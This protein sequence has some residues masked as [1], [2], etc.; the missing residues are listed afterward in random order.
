MT[1]QPF[2]VTPEWSEQT[3]TLEPDPQQ[4]LCL[5]SRHDLTHQYGYGHIADVLSNVDIDI[6]L[7]LYALDVAPAEPI[8]GDPHILRAGKDYTV[9]PARLA[10]GYVMLD[11]VRIEFAGS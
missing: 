1:D 10:Q 8:E 11:R 3:A 7:V 6:I 5:G 2:Q 9:E 4:W